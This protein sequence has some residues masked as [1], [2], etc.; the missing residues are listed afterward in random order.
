[1]RPSP[2][3]SVISNKSK[4]FL[5]VFT[6]VIDVVRFQPMLLQNSPRSIR[7][8]GVDHVGLITGY[9]DREDLED[10]IL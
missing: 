6:Q 2:N 7:G 10:F 4:A 9:T 1:M 5:H 8:G 3:L